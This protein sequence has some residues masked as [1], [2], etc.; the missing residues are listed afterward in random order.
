MCR[1]ET[2]RAG[3]PD[4]AGPV[5]RPGGHGCGPRGPGLHPRPSA[6][7]RGGLSLQDGPV[8]AL[9]GGV[10]TPAR[11]AHQTGCFP[12][13]RV[14]C[15][16]ILGDKFVRRRVHLEAHA[17]HGAGA[18]PASGGSPGPLGPRRGQAWQPPGRRWGLKGLAGRPRA[19]GRSHR[20]W[21]SRA[22]GHGQAA[23]PAPKLS[24]ASLT[25]DLCSSLFL[26]SSGLGCTPS[27]PCRAG[28]SGPGLDLLPPLSPRPGAPWPRPPAFCPPQSSLS[29][30]PVLGE[31]AQENSRLG[32][33]RASWRRWV[34]D[35]GRSTR[36]GRR[37]RA[38]PSMWQGQGPRSAPSGG[39]GTSHSSTCLGQGT[40]ILGG[41]PPA[42]PWGSRSQKGL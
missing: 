18:R 9:E 31:G 19:A 35:Q 37:Q 8:G 7:D 34:C 11:P 41:R 25:S 30:E 21:R 2:Y 24:G 22:G 39:A 15:G 10:G 42:S 12:G 40:W 26:K 28:G 6:S 32:L 4:A 38:E 3:G 23:F 14:L 5:A 13:R 16:K 33:R 36:E 20:G 29:L 1:W 17:W 27:D